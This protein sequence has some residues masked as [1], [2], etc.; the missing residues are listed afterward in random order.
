M[1]Y[2]LC[3]VVL[4]FCFSCNFASL[5]LLSFCVWLCVP[6]SSQLD[7]SLFSS[8]HPLGFSP[9]PPPPSSSPVPSPCHSALYFLHIIPLVSLPSLHP[10]LHFPSLLP[11]IFF[12]SSPRFHSLPPILIFISSPFSL[13]LFPIPLLADLFFPVQHHEFLTLHHRTV[14]LSWNFYWIEIV[15]P[16]WK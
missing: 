8:Y 13:P 16:I 11:C 6:S 3:S 7:I 9:F 5:Y 10:H 2:T 14:S 12:I 4:Y 1:L 15:I